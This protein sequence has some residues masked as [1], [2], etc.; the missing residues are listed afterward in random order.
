MIERERLRQKQIEVGILIE[1][2]RLR[3]KQKQIEGGILIERETE[4]ETEGG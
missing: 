1:R 4:T 3:Q 2:E